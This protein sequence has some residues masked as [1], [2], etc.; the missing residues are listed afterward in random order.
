MNRI[1][2]AQRYRMV[3]LMLAVFGGAA[4][5]TQSLISHQ[6]PPA[7]IN[8]GADGNAAVRCQYGQRIKRGCERRSKEMG[9]VAIGRC[10]AS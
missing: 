2:G 8:G 6:L 9:I 7:S 1:L 10:K 4:P 5:E 3:H